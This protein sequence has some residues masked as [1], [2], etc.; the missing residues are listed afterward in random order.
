MLHHRP[1]AKPNGNTTVFAFITTAVYIGE[2]CAADIPRVSPNK[3]SWHRSR[4]DTGEYTRKKAGV[5]CVD[6]EIDCHYVDV[7]DVISRAL[8]LLAPKGWATPPPPLGANLAGNH[9]RCKSPRGIFDT[10][11]RNSEIFPPW[12]FLPAFFDV[13]FSSNQLLG[14]FSMAIKWSVQLLL[15]KSYFCQHSWLFPFSWVLSVVL[16]RLSAN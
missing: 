13:S 9:R 11:T 7:C 1:A 12:E 2:D 10:S 4:R 3:K 16:L 8:S 14:N 6:E 5:E 15:I